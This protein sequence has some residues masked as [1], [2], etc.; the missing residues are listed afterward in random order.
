MALSGDNSGNPQPVVTPDL[1]AP[2]DLTQPG[3]GPEFAAKNADPNRIDVVMPP[4]PDN[5]KG[6]KGSVPKENLP[7]ALQRGFKVGVQAVS[8]EGKWGVLPAD[9]DSVAEAKK[10]G[11]HFGPAASL[12]GI[13]PPQPPAMQEAPS[14]VLGLMAEP[15]QQHSE[16]SR[17][18]AQRHANLAYGPDAA[19]GVLGAPSRIFH[20]IA[21]PIQEAEAAASGVVGGL[22]S[23]PKALA[24]VA[25]GAVNPAIPAAYFGTQGAAGLLGLGDRPSSVKQA[26]LHPTPENVQQALF[27]ASMAFGAAGEG[28]RGFK[29]IEATPGVPGSPVNRPPAPA[30]GAAMPLLRAAKRGAIDP[31]LQGV[32]GIYDPAAL[33]P[34]EAATKAFRP[35]N[36]KANW[37]AEIQSSLPHMRRAADDLGIDPENMTMEEGIQATQKAA[38]D[39]WMEYK[40]NFLGPNADV[41]VDASPVAA[42]IRDKITDRMREQ[43]PELAAKIEAVAKTYD[44]RSLTMAQLQQRVS[45]LNNEMRATEAKFVGDKRAAKLS[46]KNA[47]K[48]AERDTMRGIMDDRMNQLSGPGAAQMR[49]DYGALRSVEDVMQRRINVVDRAAREPL[50]AMMAKIYAAGHIVTGLATANPW[51]VLKGATALA[52]ERRMRLQQDPDYL[53]QLAFKNTKPST[54]MEPEPPPQGQLPFGPSTLWDINQTP[55]PEPIQPP[56]ALPPGQYEQPPSPLGPIF[57]SRQP[58]LGKGAEPPVIP[59]SRQLGPARPHQLGPV[60]EPP[61]NPLFPRLGRRQGVAEAPGGPQGAAPASLQNVPIGTLPKDL[62]SMP[63]GEPTTVGGRATVE[64]AK[65]DNMFWEQAKQALGP[66]ATFSEISSKAL[67]LKADAL[68]E[69]GPSPSG[70]PQPFET[71]TGAMQTIENDP[72]LPVHPGRKPPQGTI[73]NIPPFSGTGD[74]EARP[75]AI[76]PP[77]PESPQMDLGF[78]LPRRAGQFFSKAEQIAEAKLPKSGTGDSFLATLRN[79]GVKAEEISDL[80]LDEF[81]GKPKVTKQEFLDAV[82]SR[83]PELSQTVL[84]GDDARFEKYATPGGENYREILTHFPQSDAAAAAESFKQEADA[85]ERE[86]NDEIDR[87][88][89]ASAEDQAQWPDDYFEK[90]REALR[91]LRAQQRAAE[92]E[93]RTTDYRGG[94]FTNE[95]PNTMMHR[96]ES[97]FVTTDRMP[98]TQVHEIQSDLHQEGRDEGYR[99]KPIRQ[100]PEGYTTK[101]MSGGGYVILDQRGRPAMVAGDEAWFP[102]AQSPEDAIDGF[103]GKFNQTHSTGG[104]PNAPFKKSHWELNMKDAIRQAVEDGKGGL[105]WDTGDTQNDRYNLAKQVSRVEYDPSDSTLTAYDHSGNRVIHETAE[106]DELHRYIGDELAERLQ[107]KIDNYY[108]VNEDDYYIEPDP[109]EEDTYRVMR[110]GEAIDEGLTRKEAERSRQSYIDEDYNNQEL[111]ALRGLNDLT[112][113]GEGMKG[114]YDKMVPDFVKK[115]TKKWGG[116]V[117]TAELPT[118]ESTKEHVYVGPELTKEQVEQKFKDA[119]RNGPQEWKK[120]PYGGGSWAWFQDGQQISG[121]FPEESERNL[122]ARTISVP[123][124][125][126]DWHRVFIAMDHGIPFKEEMAN[127][128][129]LAEDIGGK[130]QTNE[131]PVTTTVHRLTFT[132]EMARAIR[133]EGQP[134]YSRE[135]GEKATA[136]RSRTV[137]SVIKTLRDVESSVDPGDETTAAHIKVNDAGQ[138]FLSS[139][140]KWLGINWKGSDAPS[141]VALLRQFADSVEKT[142][143]TTGGPE[144]AAKLRQLADQIEQV[145]AA[146]YDPNAGHAGV[147]IVHDP[148]TVSH[149]AHIHGGQRTFDP[150]GDVE[151]FTNVEK[152]LAHPAVEV[153]RPTLEAA[154]GGEMRPAHMVAELQAHILDGS[155]EELGLSKEQAVDFIKHSLD[156]LAEHH[157]PEVMANPPRLSQRYLQAMRDYVGEENYAGESAEPAEPQTTQEETQAAYPGGAGGGPAENVGAGQPAQEGAGHAGGEAGV[158]QEVIPRFLRQRGNQIAFQDLS[159]EHQ[160]GV[161]EYVEDTEPD[162]KPENQKFVKQTVQLSDLTKAKNRPLPSLDDVDKSMAGKSMTKGPLLLDSDLSV[163]DGMHRLADAIKSGKDS[164]D[165]YVRQPESPDDLKFVQL[166]KKPAPVKPTGPGGRTLV[167][168]V[169]RT[170]QKYSR[171]NVGKPLKLTADNVPQA[172]ERYVKA[173][174]PE[175]KY[176]LVSQGSEQSGADWY[177]KAISDMQS[178][179]AKNGHPELDPKKGDPTKQTLFKAMLAGASLGN[180]ELQT[181]RNG[182]GIWSEYKRTGKVPIVNPETGK[183]WPNGQFNAYM[184]GFRALQQLIDEKGE[185]GAADFLMSQHPISELRQ[186]RDSVPG[187]AG[188]QRYGGLILGDKMGPFFLNMNGIRSELTADMWE[189]RHWNRIMGTLQDPNSET[190][191]VDAPRNE[192]ERRAMKQAKEVL[193]GKLGLDTASTQA[194]NWIYEQALYNAHGITRTVSDYG[195]AA[196]AHF[197]SRNAGHGEEAPAARPHAIPARVAPGRRGDERRDKAKS[198]RGPS[199]ASS[200]IPSF[201]RRKQLESITPPPA[202]PGAIPKFLQQRNV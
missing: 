61:V 97:D 132:P 63:L 108:P 95:Q 43:N 158:G 113:G 46:P 16:L 202:A 93:A 166:R 192:T 171:E 156:V 51:S 34:T 149:E 120:T 106:P 87:H 121:A 172:V 104:P 128:P 160:D 188:D 30:E 68:R 129:E 36:S 147:P 175:A 1:T 2:P 10:R 89:N 39:K 184:H 90:E 179:F 152:T 185:K 84:A 23:D 168:D 123:K 116:K 140:S 79:N 50:A 54:P 194:V 107:K 161:H 59:P 20:A 198:A 139:G 195:E 98:V 94:H 169:G 19:P 124:A 181:V 35:R 196:R 7:A 74:L 191:L 80:G 41:V 141:R 15:W 22:T 67:Q 136:P 157:G 189:A 177:T 55:A 112:V 76:G 197:A 143:P 101:H 170:L 105:T 182:D 57:R 11:F 18:E 72:N 21:S 134:L 178:E 60:P 130:I 29:P 187:K 47:Y 81:A 85:R 190:G 159:P 127:H 45:E 86:M 70:R 148:S 40:R 53:T 77:G 102:G 75:L 5:P 201:L 82:Q 154:Y 150:E 151:N 12:G 183:G 49:K 38:V 142:R 119:G 138:D 200:L 83:R 193:A 26:I 180:K 100:L 42:A 117:D 78:G 163:M 146:N 133:E 52:A 155:H 174:L 91:N 3:K 92:A 165:A 126:S 27:D 114:F 65:A 13:R 186:Y 4:S 73:E 71:T 32:R 153:A 135:P 28:V 103:L 62:K 164:V 48:F 173:A 111:P 9:K 88:N 137:G 25:A 125:Q 58:Q 167:E 145:H 162:W 199:T 8:P 110:D 99:L 96:R 37:Q 31:L 44:G 17:E 176:Q 14:G 115:Y 122:A 144:A 131:T 64:T 24:A 33:T 118:G 6:L 109:D 69:R 56:L 66:K